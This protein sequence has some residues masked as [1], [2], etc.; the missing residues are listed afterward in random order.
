M[1]YPFRSSKAGYVRCQLLKNAEPIANEESIGLSCVK[2]R[3]VVMLIILRNL[4]ECVA[5]GANDDDDDDDAN[6]SMDGRDDS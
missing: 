2:I 5:T 6:R 3:L 1:L 4:P